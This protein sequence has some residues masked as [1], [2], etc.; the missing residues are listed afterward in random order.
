MCTKLL[1]FQAIALDPSIWLVNNLTI[2]DNLCPDHYIWIYI[3]SPHMREHMKRMQG[4]A[5]ANAC[6]LTVASRKILS[7]T[8][9][10][11]TQIKKEQLTNTPRSTLYIYE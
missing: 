8:Q 11:V 4:Q 7:M 10:P 6:R 3:H 1:L 5:S 2:L 9:A